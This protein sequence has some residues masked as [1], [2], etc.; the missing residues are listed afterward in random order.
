MDLK[1]CMQSFTE[2]SNPSWE[3][4]SPLTEDSAGTMDTAGTPSCP[5]V[6]AAVMGIENI[7]KR[8][9]YAAANPT[10]WYF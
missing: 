3:H 4:P 5:L 7:V 6:G 2:I 9:V 10:P 1:I 8:E